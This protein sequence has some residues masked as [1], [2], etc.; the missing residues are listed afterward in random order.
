MANAP[1]AWQTRRTKYGAKGR[2][3]VGKDARIILRNTWIANVRR[4]LMFA[5]KQVAAVLRRIERAEKALETEM[6]Y[7]APSTKP[8]SSTA[9]LGFPFGQFSGSTRPVLQSMFATRINELQP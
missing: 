5:R 1:K 9:Q 3:P 2:D 7:R 8:E 4:E 6:K